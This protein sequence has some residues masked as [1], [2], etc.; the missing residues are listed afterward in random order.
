LVKPCLPW[1]SLPI[2]VFEE[3]KPGCRLLSREN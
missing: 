3:D 1:L 2:Q